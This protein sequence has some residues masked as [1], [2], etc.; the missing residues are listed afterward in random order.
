MRTFALGKRVASRELRFRTRSGN[1]VDVTVLVGEAVADSTAPNGTW[2][3]PFQIVGIG[4]E[5]VRAIFGIDGFQALV[6]ALHMIP[7]E[8]RSIAREES[9]SFPDGDEDLGLTHACR[10]HLAQ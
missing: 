3:C 10:V 7:T 1:L 5:L 9:G 4:H 8:L 6:L 2:F